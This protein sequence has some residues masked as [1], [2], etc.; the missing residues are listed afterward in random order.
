MDVRHEILIRAVSVDEMGEASGLQVKCSCGTFLLDR[1]G[2]PA[3]VSL[4]E[5]TQLTM[6]HYA[7]VRHPELSN[8]HTGLIKGKK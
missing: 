4:V 7:Q 6:A 3:E 5:L 8:G 2:E 1:E